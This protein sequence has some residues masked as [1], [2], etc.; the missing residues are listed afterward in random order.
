MPQYLSDGKIRKCS[1]LPQGLYVFDKERNLPR[2]VDP[3]YEG[4]RIVWERDYA[5]KSDIQIITD[6]IEVRS[7]NDGKIYTSK[8][9]Y[10]D[11]LKASGSHIVEAGEHKPQTKEIRGDFNVRP[12]LKRALQQHLGR[13]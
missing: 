11:S 5:K 3:D 6:T 8:K 9:K 7:V 4:F 13:I 1:A 12:E 2:M 10:Y